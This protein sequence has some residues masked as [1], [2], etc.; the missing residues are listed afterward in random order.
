MILVPDVARAA[1]RSFGQERFEQ[2][3]GRRLFS[4]PQQQRRP[5]H[6]EGLRPEEEEKL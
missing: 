3:V 1:V 5:Q 6:P 4:K 2:I